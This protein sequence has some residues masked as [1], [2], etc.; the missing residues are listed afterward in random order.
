MKP[1]M[2]QALLGTILKQKADRSENGERK[3]AESS[4]KLKSALKNS[5]FS[6][7]M[8]PNI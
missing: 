1:L 6:S 4:G 5:K 3:V 8:L 2:S 7:M